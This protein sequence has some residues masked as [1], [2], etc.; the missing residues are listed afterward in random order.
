MGRGAWRYY[1]GLVW[2]GKVFLGLLI[3]RAL[4]YYLGYHGYV[5]VLDEVLQFLLELLR[6][7]DRSARGITGPHVPRVLP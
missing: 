4:T 2:I 5:P 1:S 3:L 6:A 7:I